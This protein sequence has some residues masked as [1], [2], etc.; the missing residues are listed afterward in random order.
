MKS[1]IFF[2][3]RKVRNAKTKIIFNNELEQRFSLRKY[4]IG[5]CSV[6]L[7][8]VA[9]GMGSQTVKADTVNGVEKSSTV[10]ENKVQDADSAT[11]KPNI[12]PTETKK[13]EVGSVATTAPKTNTTS[14]GVKAN[15]ADSATSTEIKPQE[16]KLAK[17]AGANND[18]VVNTSA[19]SK[20]EDSKDIE[21]K[22]KESSNVDTNEQKEKDVTLATNS[23]ASETNASS[24]PVQTVSPEQLAD[25]TDVQPASDQ[26][27]SASTNSNA[28]ENNVSAASASTVLSKQPANADTQ[29][30]ATTSGVQ[31]FMNL[32]VVSDNNDLT[33]KKETVTSRWTIHYV[34]SADHQQELKAPTVITRQYTR[35]NTIQS[36]GTIQHG[37]WSYVPGS[38]KLT[39]TPIT[40]NDSNNPVKEDNVDK[41]GKNYDVFSII[42]QHPDITGYELH[43]V[44]SGARIND[45]LQNNE[46][47]G[48][49]Q[50]PTIN[51][52]RYVEYDVAKERSVSVKFVDDQ[53]D[54]RQVGQAMTLTG[55]DGDT[56]DLKLTVPDKY[57]LADG[58]QLPTIYTFAK[59]SGD[60]TIHLVHKV[61]QRE[62]TIDVQLGLVTSIHTSY[63]AYAMVTLT[64]ARWKQLG[65]EI[66]DSVP[67]PD[68]L[69]EALPSVEVGTLTGHADYDLVDER[70]TSLGD[71]WTTLNLGGKTYQLPNGDEVVNGIMIDDSITWG[72]SFKENNL[73]SAQIEHVDLDPDYVNRP[74]HGYL[75]VNATNNDNNGLI[76]EVHSLGLQAGLVGDEPN[77]LAKATGDRAATAVE[78]S[79]K[80]IDLNLLQGYGFDFSEQDGQ[81]RANAVLLVSGVYIPYVEK[82][83]TRTI[84]ITTPDG[85]ITTVKQTATLAKQVGSG[86]DVH[87][88]WTT[89]EWANYDVPTIPGYTASQTNVAKETVTGTT[90]DQTVNITYTANDGTQTIVYQD[91]Y[92]SE[93]DKQVI[94]GKTDE[95]VKV[96][97]D[98][99]DGYVLKGEVPSEVTIKPDD[100]PI[101]VTVEHG[102]SHVTPDK[103]VNK[104][105]LIPDT[106]DKHYPE[107]LTHNDL[108]KTVT[109]EITI[110][111]PTGKKSATAQ[112]VTFTRDATVDEVTGE[113]AYGN[114]SENGKHTFDKVD[115]PT[116]QG[117][118]ASGD[119]P[120]LTVTPDSQSTNVTVTYNANEQTATITY[121][122]DTEKKTL[123]SDN[124]NGKFNQVITFEHDPTEV[125]KGLDE[126]G[127]KLVSND[128]N[129]NKY[130]ADNNNNVFYVHLKHQHQDID[131]DHIPSGA[132]DKDDQHDIMADDFSK[133]ITRTIEFET[134]AHNSSTD[135]NTGTKAVHHD[136]SVTL[137]RHGDYDKVTGL[138]TWKAWS[139]GDFDAVNVGENGIPTFDGYDIDIAKSVGY[140]KDN[141]RIDAKHVTSETKPSVVIIRYKAQD[142]TVTY[143]FVDENGKQ[144]TEP[145]GTTLIA[146]ETVG[147]K[148]D[149]TVNAPKLPDG[150]VLDGD[151]LGSTVKVPSADKTINVKIKHGQVTV[152]HD[153]PVHNGDKI[154][155]TINK[156]YGDGLTKDDLNQQGTRTI[157]F[158]FP[159]TYS[160]DDAKKV[161][162]NGD[163][164]TQVTYDKARDTAIVIQ[165]IHFTRDAVVDTVTG[166]VVE[167]KGAKEFTNSKTGEKSLWNSDPASGSYAAVKIPKVSGYKSKLE[168]VKDQTQ[169]TR[170]GLNFARYYM[171]NFMALPSNPNSNVP[172]EPA[173]TPGTNLDDATHVDK[174]GEADNKGQDQRNKGQ[175]QDNKGQDQGGQKTDD[176]KGQIP[177]GNTDNTQKSTET[178]PSNNDQ[179]PA[180]NLNADNTKSDEDVNSTDYKFDGKKSG[181]DLD[182]K[183][184]SKKSAKTV[185][186]T[187]K[188][189]AL[190]GNDKG[191]TNMVTTV[192]TTGKASDSVVPKG[193]IANADNGEVAGVRTVQAATVN[194]S[195]NGAKDL[196][197]TGEKQ[198]MIAS[199]LGA[200]ASGLGILELAG[201][202]H[203]KKED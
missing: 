78:M 72:E 68:G 75:S 18:V 37:D 47:N 197:H 67:S 23:P 163:K 59:G 44:V 19:Q 140:D 25:T 30:T 1:Q 142:H 79:N 181:N 65:D 122:D 194:G 153:N 143:H 121:I 157:V 58:Q 191:V 7:G 42:V 62:A 164:Y 156:T 199:I 11:A 5:L 174:P 43:N 51:S 35:T 21:V 86:K 56:V 119:V 36:D 154:P 50:A 49:I 106:K 189:T 83:A 129:G 116:V 74:W 127:Y 173:K 110:I 114:W 22:P 202:K 133:K 16:T 131:V 118:T 123:S 73:K 15:T 64:Q 69:V 93:I 126:K 46:S 109:R 192:S 80:P 52:D 17:T 63:D 66:K 102:K 145:D 85:K 201:A 172:S 55:R 200:L 81:L 171:V 190:N 34:N 96:T 9:I 159:K 167:Y 53:S 125:I 57:Q 124:Q 38:F 176:H 195:A 113:V 175:N 101:T 91:E 20:S 161:L 155:G 115:V 14:N 13:N 70:V 196:P 182:T 88:A 100:T 12:T 188:K 166:K 160:L 84:N 111:D 183:S 82:T 146:D 40:V 135:F 193:N 6:C 139:E 92:G 76:D 128:F 60:L 151:T 94:S 137:Q 71:D 24:K 134:P 144:Q 187:T 168:H 108:N 8:F 27:E 29:P 158:N 10:Q 184:S 177:S 162:G 203:K 2:K 39:G 170:R 99:P 90:E 178:K 186:N 77:A 54:E 138:V 3:K 61:V 149:D 112:T 150:W 141:K 48:E 198:G 152:T 28:L 130:Q 120:S 33:P 98:V 41:D 104:G 132:K 180:D 107:G 97:P 105:D 89:G 95:K 32:A 31:P 103:P 185:V 169:V 87:S 147:G 45:Y 165:T 26:L 4:T 148:T 136:Q 117:Y 179:K